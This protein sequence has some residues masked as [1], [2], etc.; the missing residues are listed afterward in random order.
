MSQRELLF[1]VLFCFKLQT[2]FSVSFPGSGKPTCC[3]RQKVG[4]YSVFSLSQQPVQHQTHSFSC[5]SM[6]TTLLQTT[7]TCLISSSG[8]PSSM[9][10]SSTQKLKQ[11]FGNVH[12]ILSCFNSL[13][14][15]LEQHPNLPHSPPGSASSSS[16]YISPFI[17]CHSL[18]GSLSTECTSLLSVPQTH[19]TSS[20]HKDVLILVLCPVIPQVS[21]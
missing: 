4:S 13:P 15:H 6:A 14:L 16:I 21:R 12:H 8:L 19:Q 10:P 11:C 7:I 3:S 17:S 9:M 18:L 20:L 2:C 5:F 1:C